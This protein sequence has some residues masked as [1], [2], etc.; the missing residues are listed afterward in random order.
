MALWMLFHLCE[1]KVIS[2]WA[3]AQTLV[4]LIP[5]GEHQWW[6]LDGY[7]MCAT[8]QRLISDLNW[9]RLDLCVTGEAGAPQG[10]ARWC[11][12]SFT[13]S[14]IFSLA[15]GFI[16]HRPEVSSVCVYAVVNSPF[17]Y[18]WMGSHVYIIIVFL[19]EGLQVC[20][21]NLD[22]NIITNPSFLREGLLEINWNDLSAGP[23]SEARSIIGSLQP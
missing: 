21:C 12:T 23:Q 5:H 8:E 6:Y 11:L 13:L 10:W 17:A 2:V 4:G 20:V 1:R 22:L 18:R 16:F 14:I 19:C 7:W 3:L 9:P 15:T